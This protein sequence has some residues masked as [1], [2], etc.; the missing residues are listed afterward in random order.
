MPDTRL[1]PK[2]VEVQPSTIPLEV[3]GAAVAALH[4]VVTDALAYDLL[5]HL[6]QCLDAPRHL[7]T[8]RCP[9]YL[10]PTLGTLRDTL[11]AARIGRRLVKGV[12]RP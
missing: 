10:R 8:I 6:G 9:E 4:L 1:E 3:D 11:S 7:R 12:V 2:A 5:E